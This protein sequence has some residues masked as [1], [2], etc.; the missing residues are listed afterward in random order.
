MK[1]VCDASCSRIIRNAIGTKILLNTKSRFRVTWVDGGGARRY[2]EIEAE[3]ESEARR[4]VP[5]PNEA[6]D[7]KWVIKL[8]EMV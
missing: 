7:G 6:A 3:H 4:I 5:S 2:V 1:W 8:V